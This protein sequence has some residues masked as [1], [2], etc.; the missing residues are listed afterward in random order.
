MPEA[1]LARPPRPARASYQG[2]WGAVRQLAGELRQEADRL[3]YAIR[4]DPSPTSTSLARELTEASADFESSARWS[5]GPSGTE[6]EYRR[7]HGAYRAVA[8]NVDRY[9]HRTT[10]A[11]RQVFGRVKALFVDK[12]VVHYE[13]SQ[14]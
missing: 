5:G 11:V 7:L 1:A 9:W 10:G 6:H 3:T 12:L 13:R 2:P 4:R 8:S 14:R